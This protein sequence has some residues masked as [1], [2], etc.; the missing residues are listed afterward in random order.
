MHGFH[1]TTSQV[2]VIQILIHQ[3]NIV[4]GCFQRYLLSFDWMLIYSES[5]GNLLSEFG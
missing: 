1:M 4:A 2:E 3:K 5:S